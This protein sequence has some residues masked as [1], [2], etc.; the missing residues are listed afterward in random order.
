MSAAIY[1]NFSGSVVFIAAY[2]IYGLLCSPIGLAFERRL[3]GSTE[4]VWTLCE[5]DK[6]VA[7]ARNRTTIPRTL[8]SC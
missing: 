8:H 7:S 1:G 4:A 3:S 2:I 5:R 6:R